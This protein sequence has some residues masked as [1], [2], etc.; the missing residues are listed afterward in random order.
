M[1][2]PEREVDSDSSKVEGELMV[3][4]KKKAKQKKEKKQRKRDL[5]ASHKD[6]ETATAE[7]NEEKAKK[8]KK[9]EKK[10]KKK[11]KRDLEASQNEEET[12]TATAE[13]KRSAESSGN[14]KQKSTTNAQDSEKAD[15]DAPSKRL[16]RS[17]PLAGKVIAV[18]TLAEMAAATC[19][20]ENFTNVMT[21]CKEAGATVSSMVHKKCYCVI[22]SATGKCIPY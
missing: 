15:D 7:R 5:V 19:P 13:S 6:E 16:K 8:Q 4:D 17:R 3:V 20:A 9:K 12:A 21:L 14:E 2:T 18:T 10:E 11:R 1:A 22:A